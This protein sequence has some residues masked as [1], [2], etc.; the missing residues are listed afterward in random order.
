M[1]EDGRTA[2]RAIID[3]SRYMVLATVGADGV[4][5]ASPLFYSTE[6]GRDFY[7]ISSPE[8]THSRNIAHEPRVA[9]VIHDSRAPVGT[10]GPLALYL[11]ATAQEVHGEEALEGLRIIP[12]PP[13]RGGRTIDT[14]EVRP[15]APWR[16][17]RARVSEYS[18]ICPREEGRCAEHWLDYEHRRTVRI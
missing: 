14:E 2:A 9:I 5:W 1:T 4:P 17:Y 3:G 15:P 8:V 7:W 6:D 16:V 13:G 18:M 12:G 10:A 11:S